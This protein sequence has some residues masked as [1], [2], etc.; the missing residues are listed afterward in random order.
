[1]VSP[2]DAMEAVATAV[3]K[4]GEL[5]AE[6]NLLL[7][8]ADQSNDDA[9][10]ELPVMEVQPIEVDNVVVNN[11]DLVGYTT[12][13][14]GN[15]TGRVYFSDYE[16]TIQIQLWTTKGDSYDPDDLGERLRTALYPHSSYGPQEPF[17]DGN[18]DPID[19]ITYFRLLTGERTDDILQTPT[20]RRWSQE[21]E[22]WGCETFSTNKDYIVDVDYPTSGDYNDDNG[23]GQVVNT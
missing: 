4:S 16:M 11:T 18:D 9:S 7:Q 5:P 22:L 1:M 23:D 13:D 17:L 3:A 8:E 14:E 15:R 6:L 21:I 19:E 20:V 12:D 2:R 10:V